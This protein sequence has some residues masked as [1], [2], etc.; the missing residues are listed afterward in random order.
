MRE[1]NK[2]QAELLLESAKDSLK[3]EIEI[4]NNCKNVEFK[5]LY[6]KNISKFNKTIEELE[7][8]LC[9]TK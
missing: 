2:Q 7:N 3:K 1:I 6:K 9:I 8:I 5:E 4:Y